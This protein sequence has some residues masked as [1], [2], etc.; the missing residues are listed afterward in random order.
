M[1]SLSED[2]S[3]VKLLIKHCKL[4]ENV[5][6]FSHLNVCYFQMTWDTRVYI[7]KEC[8]L[9]PYSNVYLSFSSLLEEKIRYSFR[10]KGRKLVDR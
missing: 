9:Y 6:L 1:H 8:M 7:Q 5:L 10:L 3:V 2:P 4:L